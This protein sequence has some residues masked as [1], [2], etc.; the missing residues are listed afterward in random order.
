MAMADNSATVNTNTTSRERFDIQYDCQF[1]SH[2]KKGVRCW[3]EGEVCV[4]FERTGSS[5]TPSSRCDRDRDDD[6]INIR[7][8]DGYDER[9]RARGTI[10][11]REGR[12][13]D[14]DLIIKADRD[15]REGREDRVE[16]ELENFNLDTTLAS[17]S[18]DERRREDRFRA[19][20]TR[21]NDKGGRFFGEC[22]LR[23]ER[24]ERPVELQ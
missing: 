9:E 21:D 22:R 17:A 3:V 20:F 11:R 1:R 8:N 15:R 18:T 6:R 14:F 13:R 5:M 19:S 7:C 4:D 16:V 23:L 12:E 10:E 24:S 2:H